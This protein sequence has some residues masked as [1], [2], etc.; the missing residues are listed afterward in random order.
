MAPLKLIVAVTNAQITATF[1]PS[2]IGGPIEATYTKFASTT[3]TP[4]PPSKIGGPIE[5]LVSGVVQGLWHYHFH[6]VKS[7]APLKQK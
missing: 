3:V 1:P 6:R 2:K 5:A 4:F 7:V